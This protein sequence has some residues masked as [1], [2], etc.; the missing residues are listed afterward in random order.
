MLLDEVRLKCRSDLVGCLQRVIDGPV[1]CGVVNH[2]ASITRSL[3]RDAASGMHSGK[4]RGS[5]QAPGRSLSA[6]VPGSSGFRS[7]RGQSVSASTMWPSRGRCFLEEDLDPGDLQ[8]APAYPV[9][10]DRPKVSLEAMKIDG[11][12]LCEPEARGERAQSRRVTL[13]RRSGIASALS[14]I[15]RE[16]RIPGRYAKTWQSWNIE[17]NSFPAVASDRSYGRALADLAPSAMEI[18]STAP[19]A[20]GASIRRLALAPPHSEHMPCAR[21][22]AGR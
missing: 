10:P 18:G 15:L 17:S 22:R 3:L 16:A 7:C 5:R 1:S 9:T 8:R 13:T 2:A 20:G 11:M 21:R 4:C 14:A 6:T 19:C 12:T